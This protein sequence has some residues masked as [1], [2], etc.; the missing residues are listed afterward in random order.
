MGKKPNFRIV[1]QTGY[2][3]DVIM[4]ADALEGLQPQLAAFQKRWPNQYDGRPVAVLHLGGTQE[5]AGWV[6]STS[7]RHATD[8]ERRDYENRA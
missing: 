3:K 2:G 1:M 7:V 5:L 6:S 4:E 8:N